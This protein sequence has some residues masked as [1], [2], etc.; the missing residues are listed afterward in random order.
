MMKLPSLTLMTPLMLTSISLSS[1]SSVRSRKYLLLC[2]VCLF[3]TLPVSLSL[4]MKKNELN[5]REVL[6]SG[7]S[8]AAV[9]AAAAATAT[10]ASTLVP[11]NAYADPLN[12]LV[13]AGGGMIQQPRVI[14]SNDWTMPTK[15]YTK[16]GTS[17]FSSTSLG[18]LQQPPFGNQ[19][20]Y[21]APFLFGSWN[22]TSTLQQKI[23]PFGPDFVPSKSLL[24]GSPRNRNEQV[25]DTTTFQMH[26]FSTM[27]DTLSN[28][29]TVNL[30]LGIPQTKI[31]ADRRFNI[32]SASKAYQQL[33]PIEE[34]EW[35]Y[36]T[37]PTR[38]TLRSGAGPLADD[39]RPLGARRTEVYLSA[40]Q[41]ESSSTEDESNNVISSFCTSERSRSV[42]V[43]PGIVT[44]NDQETITE[45]HKLDDDTV[46]A[47]SRV[48]IYL[49]PN[50]NSREG[51]LWQQ[52]GGKGVAIYDYSWLMKREREEFTLQD[53]TKAY[54]P[55]VRTP[56]DVIQ[57]G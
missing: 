51:I 14:K 37:D 32:I 9:V 56:K 4:S 8:A 5:R 33:S 36:Q 43:A 12:A 30:G 53:G 57:C 28:Q 40:R 23:F 13:P 48:V 11:E 27:A 2:I 49:T 24:E 34:V 1:S 39:M 25:D 22:V 55:C 47:I 45:F 3:L 10:V 42:T 16:L 26:F 21:F 18:P 52:V 50:P 44:A 19:E 6:L 20:L 29:L 38:L 7:R 46:E 54:Q 31:I 15:F 17:R 35:D 41:T